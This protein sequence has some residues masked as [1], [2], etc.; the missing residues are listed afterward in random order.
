[1]SFVISSVFYLFRCLIFVTVTMYLY[2]N[3]TEGVVRA[4]TIEARKLGSIILELILKDL[5]LILVILGVN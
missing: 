5:D 2:E 4:Y 3:L 1:M